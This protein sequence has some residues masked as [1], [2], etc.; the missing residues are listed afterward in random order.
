M[1]A[2][3]AQPQHLRDFELWEIGTINGTIEGA[4]IDV[5]NAEDELEEDSDYEGSIDSPDSDSEAE[6]DMSRALHQSPA[7]KMSKF[8]YLGKQICGICL[9]NKPIKIFY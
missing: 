1:S 3:L 7:T 9:K 2:G 8:C 6:V 5:E 4:L